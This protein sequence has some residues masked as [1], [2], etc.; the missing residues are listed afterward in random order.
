MNENIAAA[1]KKEKKT[2][3]KSYLLI[4]V[5]LL[6][7]YGRN[8]SVVSRKLFFNF[9]YKSGIFIEE[10]QFLKKQ[11]SSISRPSNIMKPHFYPKKCYYEVSNIL[12]RRSCNNFSAIR[13]NKID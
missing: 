10:K 8:N 13:T 1:L 3:I 9:L 7:I 4:S 2:L 5:F 6:S 11:N 12:F